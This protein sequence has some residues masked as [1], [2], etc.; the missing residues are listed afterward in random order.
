[1]IKRYGVSALWILLFFPG[2]VYAH[3]PIEGI[4]GFYNGIAHPLF[5]PAHLLLILTLGL[6]LGQQGQERSRDALRLFVTAILSGLIVAGF[7]SLSYLEPVLLGSAAV[8]G[9]LTAANSSIGKYWFLIIAAIAGFTIGADS[10]QETLTGIDKLLSLLGSGLGVLVLLGA[11][12]MIVDSLNKETWHG[13]GI[14]VVGSWLATSALLVLALSF[15]SNPLG[16]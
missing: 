3:S 12:M 10:A 13:I 11:P 15:S 4:N 1:M 5:V 9:L 2:L 6:Y 16:T 7:T 8:C 14:R